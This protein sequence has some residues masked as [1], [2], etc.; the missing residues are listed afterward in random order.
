MQLNNFDW[1]LSILLYSQNYEIFS[2]GKFP[3][4][5]RKYSIFHIYF[6]FGVI[7]S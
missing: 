6:F 4:S 1:I 5:E 2:D 7:M 3:T